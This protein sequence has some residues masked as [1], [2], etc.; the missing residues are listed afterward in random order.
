MCLSDGEG[1]RGSECPVQATG[2][3]PAMHLV[4]HSQ[5]KYRHALIPRDLSFRDTPQWE[6]ARV[7]SPKYIF[8]HK[9][10]GAAICP[11]AEPWKKAGGVLHGYGQEPEQSSSEDGAQG[12][13]R[14]QHSHTWGPR[15]ARS[16]SKRDLHTRVHSS[17]AHKAKR[18]RQGTCPS[19]PTD[20]QN[21]GLAHREYH[22]ALKR[23]D[24]RWALPHA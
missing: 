9:R 24:S 12:H 17:G 10:S 7:C 3:R 6:G 22:S 15:A 11:S 23:R 14:S 16:T 5:Q 4:K 21:T 8:N 20:K 2:C 1:Q 19:P 18:W 13:H